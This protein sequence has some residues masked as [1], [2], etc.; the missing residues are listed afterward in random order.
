RFHRQE[1]SPSPMEETPRKS[2]DRLT[3]LERSGIL[4]PMNTLHNA[5][6][7]AV[8]S[9]LVEGNSLRA[10]CRMTGVARNTVTKLLEDIG[11]AC[12]AYFDEAVMGVEAK[13]IQVDEI[14]S[15]CYAKAKNVPANLKGIFGYGDVWTW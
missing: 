3:M 7:I 13:Q 9:A 15:F 10:T 8:V 11:A 4:A 1:G 14:W 12:S 5:R 6:R 2:R